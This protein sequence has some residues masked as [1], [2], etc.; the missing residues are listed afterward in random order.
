MAADSRVWCV[1][2]LQ[3]SRAVVQ[4]SGRTHPC[5]GKDPGVLGHHGRGWRVQRG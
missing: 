2:A 3:E 5:W 4:L 1:W